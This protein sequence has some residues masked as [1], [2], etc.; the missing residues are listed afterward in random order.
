[1]PTYNQQWRTPVD[2][3]SGI[4]AAALA[5]NA[6]LA[7]SVVANQT[8]LEDTLE[9]ELLWQYAI[10][11]SA[12]TKIDLY[13]LYSVD[14]TNYEEGGVG[15]APIK[16]LADSF[17]VIADTNAHRRHFSLDLIHGFSFKVLLFNNATGQTATVTLLL[18][19][20]GMKMVQA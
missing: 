10:A 2:R 18:K 15:A 5:N 6:Y 14:G 1:M 3:S 9:G 13:I 17:T 11:P 20:T 12:N 7:S 8:N 4:A 16:T 19:T